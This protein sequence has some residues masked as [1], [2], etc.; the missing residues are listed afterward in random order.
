MHAP[1]ERSARLIA[2]L[3]ELAAQEE[4]A[5]R[6]GELAGVEAVQERAAA[7]VAGLAECVSGMDTAGRERL[8]AVHA[9]RE[10][11]SGWLSAEMTRAQ[12]ELRE[13]GLARHRVARLA[14]VY[15]S[16]PAEKRPSPRVSL[17]G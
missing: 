9:R 2:A 16:R 7:I 10:H 4:A 6:S 5:I 17:V 14:P 12:A 15:G 11:T 13:T 8:L 1:A 3:E